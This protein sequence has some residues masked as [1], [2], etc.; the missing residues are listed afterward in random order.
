MEPGAQIGA[1]TRIWAFA[2]ILPAAKI[3]ADCN[4][5][6]GVFI[7]NDVS[8]GDRVTIKGGV[9]LWDGITLEE[10]VFVGPNATFA[11]DPFPRSKRYPEQFVRTLI[12]R[13]ASIG[14]N[15]TILPGVSVGRHAMVG[16]G[17]VVSRDVPPNAVVMGVPAR[18]TG[19]VNADHSGQLKPAGMGGDL[20]ELNA[21]GAALINLHV[22]AEP[23][24]SLAVNEMAKLLPFSPVRYFVVYDVP[25][26][27]VR[28]GHAHRVQHQF[29]TCLRGSVHVMVDDGHHRA[30][31]ILDSPGAGLHIPPRRWAYQYKYSPGS[32]LLA[33]CSDGYDPQEYINDYDEFLSI[34]G[35]A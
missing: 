35:A 11:N 1:R 8:I 10:D 25:P 13:G 26:H 16:A 12:K 31:V 3:G 22:I 2:H 19:F 28:G 6:D 34:T 9:Q 15:A 21:T 29:L 14:A 32:A 17:A 18:V 33:L 20:A 5:C 4:I 24:G 23:G 30:E 27:E 7:E